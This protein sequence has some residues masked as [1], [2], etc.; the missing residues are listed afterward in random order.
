MTSKFVNVHAIL[1]RSDWTGEFVY[2]V[3][4]RCD[5]YVAV[6]GGQLVSGQRIVCWVDKG[7]QE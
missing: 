4:T 7:W 3:R 5:G 1:G 2:S 6:D